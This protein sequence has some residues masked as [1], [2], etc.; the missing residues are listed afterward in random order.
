MT[1]FVFCKDPGGCGVQDRLEASCIGGYCCHPR[2]TCWRH[3]L[4]WK[5]REA[6]KVKGIWRIKLAEFGDK[7]DVE[8]GRQGEEVSR[9]KSPFLA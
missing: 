2:K 4:G 3:G 5:W 1:R 9:T 8:D 6:D 7:L